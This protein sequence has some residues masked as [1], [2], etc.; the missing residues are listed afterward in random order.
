MVLFT[1]TG[2]IS[3]VLS[4]TYFQKSVYIPHPSRQVVS[5]PGLQSK[6]QMEGVPLLE[7]IPVEFQLGAIFLLPIGSSI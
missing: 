3:L 5:E 1:S 6:K 4:R 7:A 2:L